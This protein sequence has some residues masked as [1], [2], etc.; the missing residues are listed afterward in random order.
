MGKSTGFL[1]Y[2]REEPGKQ[3]IGERTRHFREFESPLPAED[4]ERQA[5][6]CM[7]C[8]IP[9]CHAYGCPVQNRVPDWCDA[10]Y[11]GR[12]RDAL[13][14]LHFADNLPEVTGRVC[15]AP[16]EAA[17]TL[18]VNQPAVTV[19]NIELQIIERGWREGW[20]RPVPAEHKTGRRVAVVGSGPAGLSAAQQL[21]RTGHE[22]VV[23][24][25][26]DRIGG[27]LRYGI[28]DFKL[29]KWV[30][31]RRLEQLHEEGV[32]FETG[33][34]AG[35]DV[36][37]AYLRRFFDATLITVGAGR[38][39]DLDLSGRDLAGVHFAME[40]LTQ[41]NLRLAGDFIPPDQS[42]TA[43]GK[44]VVVVGG[45]DTGSDCV[46]TSLRQGCA[47]LTQIELLPRP[48][49]ER[50]P[51]NPWP[52][53]PLTLR[54]SSSQ[55]EGGERRWSVL[56]KA[57]L[58]DGG[59]VTGLRCVRLEWSDS[60]GNG[61]AACREIPDSAFELE[62]DLVLLAMGFVHLEHGP[63]VEDLTKD[64]RGDLEVDE[65]FMTSEKGVFA[66]GDAVTG[67]SLVVR[68]IHHARRAARGVHRYLETLS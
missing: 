4:L 36:S 8:G 49:D 25:K 50:A 34:E 63:L 32:V 10:V 56:T 9:Y 33:I 40:F 21:A 20:V 43:Q 55:E 17:C 24:E 12:W 54:T 15:P 62:A 19:R 16:C 35:V 2:E 5:A 38:P 51:D 18:A 47:S 39:R 45:G 53:W 41:Q 22:V 26:S 42:V 29:E 44:R 14:L 52:T 27:L 65:R 68:A 31:D 48:P 64:E 37:M 23:F 59:R 3:D 7:D 13:E 30:I 61:D 1:D 28:P 58:G 11:R 66:A 46:G 60:D 67:A 6:R 57:F